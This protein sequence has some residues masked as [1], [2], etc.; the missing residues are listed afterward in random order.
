VR[1]NFLLVE[2]VSSSSEFLFAVARL[3]HMLATSFTQYSSP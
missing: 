3:R 2:R 1:P